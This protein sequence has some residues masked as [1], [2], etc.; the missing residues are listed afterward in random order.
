[1]FSPGLCH[2]LSVKTN[3]LILPLVVAATSLAFVL[4]PSVGLANTP[5]EAKTHQAQVVPQRF[6]KL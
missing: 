5:A 6:G 2:G 4:S 3:T 1:M